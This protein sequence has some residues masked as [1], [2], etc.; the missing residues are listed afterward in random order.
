MVIGMG[1]SNG[2]GWST[3]PGSTTA[4]TS[5]YGYE[6]YPSGA[7]GVLIPMGNNLLG[8]TQGGP[9]RAFSQTW[10]AGGGGPVIWVDAAVNGC[11]MTKAAKSAL[12]GS[13]VNLGGGTWD[14][15]DSANVYDAWAKPLITSAI[16]VAAS[17]GFD[18]RERVVTWVQGESDG[19]A[20]ALTNGP[21]YRTALVSLIDRLVSD[22]GIDAFVVSKLGTP[23]TGTTTYWDAI[24]QA[25]VDAVS[26]RS[27]VAV[28]G[29]TDAE[30]FA[31]AGKMVDTLHYTQAGYNEMGAALA[32]AA[33]TFIG[34]PNNGATSTAKHE[35]LASAFPAISG[36]KRIRMTT[37]RNGAFP[38]AFFS[39]PTTPFA[40]TW[41]DGS[42]TQPQSAEQ[43]LS[44][45]FG[46]AATK[47]VVAYVS[48][49]I[50]ASG[51]LT[52][53]SNCAV[54]A[55][56][57]VDSGIKLNG[58]N[59]G[60]AGAQTSGLTVTGLATL[61]A[62]TARSV[63]FASTS[64][65]QIT[66]ADLQTLT[67]LTL[68]T[69][70]ASATRLIDVTNTPNLTRLDLVNC[71]L[72]TSDVNAIL[73]ALDANGKSNGLVQITQTPSA[74]PSGAGAT[75]KTSLQGKGWTVST[76]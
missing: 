41:V 7:S 21:A 52:G 40:T 58:I 65:V 55:I 69:A 45:S 49:T 48:D 4:L 53:G 56:D 37:A 26:D 50:G 66:T 43:T 24:R 22:F 67:G 17:Y 70:S 19:G 59:F 75:A 34:A 39:D 72:S 68:I 30:N 18:V 15:T 13:G 25:Q 74:P 12:T 33:H 64:A 3:N 5:G 2:K 62:A 27:S 23:S 44:W 9:Q 42:G 20:N 32:T 16:A 71:A 8:R 6:F 29:F 73:V 63:A 35:A 47:Q 14:L 76:N 36:F 51:S 10:C 11:T 57:F 1:Q 38:M 31:G 54:S 60:T 61:N 28:V 46:S